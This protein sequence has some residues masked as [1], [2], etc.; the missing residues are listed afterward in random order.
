MKKFIENIII[1]ISLFFLVIFFIIYLTKY[2]GRFRINTDKTMLIVGHSHSECAFNDSLIVGLSNFST[3]GESYFYT[4]YKVKKIIEQ[5]PHIRCLFIE[6][7]NNQIDKHMDEWIWGSSYLINKFPKYCM[8]ID[9]DGIKLL[10]EKNSNGLKATILPIIKNNILIVKNGLN[11][12]NNIGSYKYLQRNKLVQ[13]LQLSQTKE[14]SQTISTYNLEYLSKLI[15]Y[16]K[17][18]S[19][20]TYLLRSPLHKHY[21]GF[22]N[23]KLFDIIITE[24]FKNIEFLD[25]A[26]FILSDYEYG[27]SE[28][29]N[30]KGARKFSSWFNKLLISGLLNISDKQEYIDLEINKRNYN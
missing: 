17:T 15:A 28:H 1:F 29:L 3:S 14:N 2:H 19:V 16:C 27:D 30:F 5:N 24:K 10:H 12:N 21:R 20:K 25:F 22:N 9:Y 8:F 4:Y 18:K 7:S 23:E 6:I 26:G 11:Y 13:D